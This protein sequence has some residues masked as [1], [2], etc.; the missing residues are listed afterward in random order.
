MQLF[1][2][3]YGIAKHNVNGVISPSLMLAGN[4][5]TH[6]FSCS[7]FP[8][9]KAQF[10]LISNVREKMESSFGPFDQS[11]NEKFRYTAGETTYCSI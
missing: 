4:F 2:E 11:K 3:Q 5:V 9:E 1:T 7:I 8:S 6:F 10:K